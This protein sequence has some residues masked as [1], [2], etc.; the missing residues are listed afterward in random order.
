MIPWKPLAVASIFIVCTEFLAI[1]P[2][3][4]HA[5]WKSA[6]GQSGTC[7]GASINDN[8][9]VSIFAV[10]PDPGMNRGIKRTI[11]LMAPQLTGVLKKE[12]GAKTD[13]IT[14]NRYYTDWCEYAMAGD[15]TTDGTRGMIGWTVC[16]QANPAGRCDQSVVRIS[17][18]YFDA[19]GN[20]A[21]RWIVCHEIGHSI[22]L[23]HRTVNASVQETPG[24]MWNGNGVRSDVKYTAHDRRHFSANWNTEPRHLTEP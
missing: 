18:H 6:T 10:A 8:K 17:R 5:N 24:C 19:H 7:T 20:A 21:D 12:H 14:R 3:L 11:K 2:R 15:W 1:S 22:G 9:N 23:G 16:Y 13:V 4:A